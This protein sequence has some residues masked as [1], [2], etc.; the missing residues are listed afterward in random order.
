[1]LKLG[2]LIMVL[3][4]VAG[5]LVSCSKET[6]VTKKAAQKPSPSVEEPEPEPEYIPPEPKKQ[7]SSYTTPTPST[8]TPQPQ[9]VPPTQKTPLTQPKT[10]TTKVNITRKVISNKTTS[11]A[12]SN[13][14]SQ[15]NL[16]TTQNITNITAAKNQT[17]ITQSGQQTAQQAQAT[18]AQVN[19]TAKQKVALTNAKQLSAAA[20]PL[21][22]SVDTLKAASAEKNDPKL[23]DLV[24][25]LSK[26]YSGN[27]ISVNLKLLSDMADDPAKFDKQKFTDAMS[28]L[29]AELLAFQ[30]LVTKLAVHAEDTQDAALRTQAE[31]L[32]KQ[33]AQLQKKYDEYK[34]KLDKEQ[35]VK[36]QPLS[37]ETLDSVATTLNINTI[38]LNNAVIQL[39]SVQTT[40][41]IIPSQKTQSLQCTLAFDFPAPNDK[42]LP[43]QGAGI[44]LH[45]PVRATTFDASSTELSI[46]GPSSIV[47]TQLSDWLDKASNAL[48]SELD[49]YAKDIRDGNIVPPEF[50]LPS[51]PQII[52][53]V[54]AQDTSNVENKDTITGAATSPATVD[55]EHMRIADELTKIASLLR[56]SEISTASASLAALTTEDL[57]IIQS[58]QLATSYLDQ[59]Q[60][61][62]MKQPT[63]FK[64]A[65]KNL[66]SEIISTQI[67][68]NVPATTQTPP[69]SL[70]LHISTDDGPWSIQQASLLHDAQ[71]QPLT[72]SGGT[73]YQYITQLPGAKQSTMLAISHGTTAG[74]TSESVNAAI[75]HADCT[76][77]MSNYNPDISIERLLFSVL[78]SDGKLPNL[79]DLVVATR[80]LSD[81]ELAG[82]PAGTH[83]L[84]LEL[85]GISN[86]KL[87]GA[88]VRTSFEPVNSS[89]LEEGSTT[90]LSA[91]RRPLGDNLYALIMDQQ[92]SGLPI[93]I[94]LQEKQQVGGGGGGGVDASETE[95]RSTAPTDVSP[96]VE[97]AVGALLLI[98]ATMGWLVY[99]VL[100]K[101]VIVKLPKR[102]KKRR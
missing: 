60:Q 72:V 81:E 35:V 38:E 37:Q 20:A 59:I 26:L 50:D 51:E 58:L 77:R 8:T 83:E 13:I 66:P 10:T 100:R 30:L 86:A 29:G 61:A 32:N 95:I 91:V 65:Y 56:D 34:A 5:L 9:V 68:F 23:N 33:L 62:S 82:S 96:P 64:L 7:E 99:I 102:G 2:V 80:I 42:S 93:Y 101:K 1:M 12:K 47:A 89:Y 54:N 55:K 45:L 88:V 94:A 46:E 74:T 85:S 44:G 40:Q 6:P 14:S 15:S 71:G 78:P 22:A 27:T 90:S 75:S 21:S 67:I 87:T 63:Y 49:G 43:F 39:Q 25:Q 76:L 48:A 84:L 36:S 57:I 11:A 18:P 31:Q 52:V 41:K 79:N 98:A 73:F 19:L 4:L 16:V 70:I 24:A 28:Q 17:N 69:P 92:L 53:G 3:F 97:I